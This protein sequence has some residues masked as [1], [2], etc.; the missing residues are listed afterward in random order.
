VSYVTPRSICAALGFVLITAFGIG[1]VGCGDGRPP[2][3]ANQPG[4]SYVE[5]T[6]PTADLNLTNQQL[7]IRVH[8]RFPDDLPH[9][10]AWFQFYF[11]LN[12]GKSGGSVIRK[13]GRELNEE[14]DIE[15]SASTAFL[16]RK[17][18]SVKIKVQQSKS[19]SGP[20]HDVSDVAAVDS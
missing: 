16:K 17:G 1:M 19:K 5:L 7:V 4:D 8:Y 13:Q 6:D 20:W 15:A 11:E 18:V 9:P 2:G 14:G 12:D 10:D 3:V